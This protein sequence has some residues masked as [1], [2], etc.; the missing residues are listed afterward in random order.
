MEKGFNDTQPIR[1]QPED[2]SGIIKELESYFLNAQ[3]LNDPVQLNTG[4][5]IINA[6]QFIKSHL[7]IIKANNGKLIFRP[8]LNR[9]QELKTILK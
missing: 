2:W 1:E 3:T 9:L 5:K 7:T 4:T 6:P 8:Y